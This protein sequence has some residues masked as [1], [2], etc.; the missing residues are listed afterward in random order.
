MKT[1]PTISTHNSAGAN[2]RPGT[3]SKMICPECK[4]NGNA[5]RTALTWDSTV[6]QCEK[7]SCEF[8]LINSDN[9]TRKT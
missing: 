5:H 8:I 2:W 7:C 4:Y 9:D 6:I 1:T 3:T